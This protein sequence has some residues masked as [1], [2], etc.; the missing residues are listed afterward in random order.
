MAHL[1]RESR[2]SIRTPSFT[3]WG[4]L[5]RSSMMAY[6]S[7]EPRN[8]PVNWFVTFSSSRPFVLAVDLMMLITMSAVMEFDSRF[9]A[10]MVLFD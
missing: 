10:R 5:G 3:R 6:S 7:A 1:F 9:R 4:T 8:C 2:N